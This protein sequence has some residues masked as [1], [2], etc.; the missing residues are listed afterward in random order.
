MKIHELINAVR[1]AHCK[2]VNSDRDA[3]PKLRVYIESSYLH[4]CMHE[5]SNYSSSEFYDFFTRN[6]IMGYPVYQVQD[7]DGG[8]KHEPFCIVDPAA[9]GS[10]RS[11]NICQ[12]RKQVMAL[13][14]RIKNAKSK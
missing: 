8:E 10:D 11:V 9:P 5:V 7:R 13:D 14:E 1:S 4:E 6:S 12:R 2:I 3:K